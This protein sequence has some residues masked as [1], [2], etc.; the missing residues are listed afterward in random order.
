MPTNLRDIY[1]YLGQGW[2]GGRSDDTPWQDPR[3]Q[4]AGPVD[5]AEGAHSAFSRT[6][7][8][9]GRPQW[10]IRDDSFL[11]NLNREYAGAATLE[12]RRPGGESSYQ[13]GWDTSRLPRTRFGTVDMTV[14]VDE[15]T[16]VRNQQYV[17]DDPVYG[18][19]THRGNVHT[20]SNALVGP[21]LMALAGLGMGSLAGAA[22]GAGAANHVRSAMAA[23][24][25]LQG[26]G[27][28]NW[29]SALTGAAGAFGVPTWATSLARLGMQFGNRR[30]G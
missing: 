2:A 29:A 24:R 21:G 30:R 9:Y 14:P 22:G 4:S 13:L 12:N 16:Q 25:G 1:R 23:L 3:L 11:G 17:Y 18:R 8:D 7:D 15:R 10:S 5:W 28:G 27:Q 6:T 20:G 26:A 19:I